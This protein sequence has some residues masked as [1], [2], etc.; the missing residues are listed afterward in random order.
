M[1]SIPEEIINIEIKERFPESTDSKS[2]ENIINPNYITW[3]SIQNQPGF[4][5]VS[6]PLVFLNNK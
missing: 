6:F 5:I 2:F 4:E 1:F 3:L